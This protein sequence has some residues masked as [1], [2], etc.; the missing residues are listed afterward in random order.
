M[1]PYDAIAK[2]NVDDERIAFDRKLLYADGDIVSFVDKRLKWNGAG[3][4]DGLFA[5]SF[6][7]R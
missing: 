6:N 2:R 3:R 1:A 5:G 7:I 4:Y